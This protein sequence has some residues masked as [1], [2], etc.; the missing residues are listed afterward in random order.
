MG[1]KDQD[2]D[3]AEKCPIFSTMEFEN[4]NKKQSRSKKK[5]SSELFCL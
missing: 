5:K 2:R 3:Y 1:Q 4:T